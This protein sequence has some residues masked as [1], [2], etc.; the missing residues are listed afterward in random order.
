VPQLRYLGAEEP[1]EETPAW[2]LPAPGQVFAVYAGR[3]VYLGRGATADVTVRSN[4]VAPVHAMVALMPESVDRLVV[5]DLGS[6]NGT[7]ADGEAIPTAVLSPGDVFALAGI[8]RFA[9][10][11]ESPPRVE[12]GSPA[13]VR[14]R[15]A[16]APTSTGSAPRSRLP[17]PRCFGPAAH[18]ARRNRDRCYRGRIVLVQVAIADIATRY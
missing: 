5:V 12:S 14:P 4:R 2:E 17:A 8:F 15:S 6:T 13:P 3:S 11:S 18:R 7:V 16:S 1:G 10:E 9:F